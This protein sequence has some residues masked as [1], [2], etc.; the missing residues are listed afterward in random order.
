MKRIASTIALLFLFS[1]AFVSCTKD[2]NMSSGGSSTTATST[3]ITQGTWKV[4]YFNDSGTDETGNYTGYM[5]TF[6][7]GGSAG[8]ILG[9]IVTNGI[10]NSYN[11]NSDNKLYLSFGSTP[12]LSKLK[13]DWHIV[14][15]TSIKIRMED[16]SGGGN[17]T[18]DYLT[19]EKI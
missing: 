8:A 18:T 6:V 7:S 9:S 16:T 12:P 13:A 15:K 19:L 17:G 1:T 14:E 5:F 2:N 3:I 11:D 10:W 4:T